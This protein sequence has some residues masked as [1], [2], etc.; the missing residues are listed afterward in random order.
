MR[1]QY[2]AGRNLMSLLLHLAENAGRTTADALVLVERLTALAH[3]YAWLFRDR[4]TPAGTP[5]PTTFP[6][7][8]PTPP[9][10]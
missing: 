3:G 4:S 5:Q 9:A 6:A 8:P 7:S 1:Q 2:D 10:P